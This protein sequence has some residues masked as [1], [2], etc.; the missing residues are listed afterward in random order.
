VL[1][2]LEGRIT[3]LV[4][5]TAYDVEPGGLVVFPAGRPSTFEVV[6]ESARFLGITTGDGAGPVPE[7]DRL[8]GRPRP[9]EN[10]GYRWVFRMSN[11]VGHL[12]SHTDYSAQA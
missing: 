9:T 8:P 11:S 12:S 3:A 6:G 2:L 4:D 5:G 1:F 10:D 7:A